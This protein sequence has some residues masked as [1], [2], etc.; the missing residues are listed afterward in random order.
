MIRDDI[1]NTKI[2]TKT[3]K[4]SLASNK[5]EIANIQDDVDSWKPGVIYRLWS[6]LESF[7]EKA[8]IKNKLIWTIFFLIILLASTITLNQYDGHF[9][10]I[11][12]ITSITLTAAFIPYKFRYIREY[13]ID[14]L[15]LIA[16]ICANYY[17]FCPLLQANGYINSAYNY[18]TNNAIK[19]YFINNKEIVWL[20]VFFISSTVV[21]SILFYLYN[22][23]FSRFCNFFQ[24][25]I[26]SFIYVYLHTA[27]ITYAI[28][29]LVG[30]LGIM[31]ND[32]LASNEILFA[33][34]IVGISFFVRKEVEDKIK[35]SMKLFEHKWMHYRTG[36]GIIWILWLM[37]YSVIAI[38]L[39]TGQ[40]EFFKGIAPGAEKLTPEGL[41]LFNIGALFLIF[42][43]F[44]THLLMSEYSI[45]RKIYSKTSPNV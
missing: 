18:T 32:S 15:Q 8:S 9:V 5:P 31:N 25:S 27:L 42:I 4:T 34:L 22:K 24:A 40:P 37:C 20:I 13:L 26:M 14:G 3:L 2:Q 16:I 30:L 35:R 11:I 33:T 38:T 7:R 21:I 36:P 19:K 39:A 10:I 43:W 1:M 12:M 28:L 23:A 29:F 44:L 17:F 45:D 6:W 41:Q